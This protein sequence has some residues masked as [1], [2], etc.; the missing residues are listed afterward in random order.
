MFAM[1]Y[2]LSGDTDGSG[3]LTDDV[4]QH[5]EEEDVNRQ[6]SRQVFILKN[7]LDEMYKRR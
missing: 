7:G 5:E 4:P 3:I 6:T 2:E 1:N